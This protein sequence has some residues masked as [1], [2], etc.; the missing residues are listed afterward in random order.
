MEKRTTKAVR[1]R[2]AAATAR[3]AR[4]CRRLCRVRQSGNVR[5]RL[6]EGGEIRVNFDTV[7]L[8]GDPLRRAFAGEG[9][10]ELCKLPVNRALVPLWRGPV[11]ELL[12]LK[13]VPIFQ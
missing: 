1:R 7:E 5:S 2:G 13:R 10:P 6:R 8:G 4:A 9:F 12:N 11:N 3:A